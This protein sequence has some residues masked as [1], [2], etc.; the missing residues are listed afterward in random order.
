M[1]KS[2][3]SAILGIISGI[4]IGRVLSKKNVVSSEVGKSKFKQY[5]HMLNMWLRL[6]QEGKSLEKYFV[7]N[8]Y[9]Y[10]AIYGM[11]EVGNRLYSELKDSSIKV[12]YAIDKNA[13]FVEDGLEIKSIDEN[14][15]GVDVIIVTAIFAFDE[16]MS[17]IEDKVSCAVISLEDIIYEVG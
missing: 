3:L 17:D 5:Y 6:K 9:K 12:E 13:G 4:G 7:D 10:I 8:N 2:I 15:E 14:L 11:G 1:K 16:I